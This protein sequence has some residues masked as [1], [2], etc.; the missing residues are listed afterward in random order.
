MTRDLFGSILFHE[1]QAEVDLEQVLKYALTPVP[2]S[3]SHV[4]GTIQKTPKSKLLRELEKRLES[5]TQTKINVT[6]ID[7]MFFRHFLHDPPPFG[8]VASHV[9]VTSLQ[10]ERIRIHLAFDKTISPSIKDAERCKSS[11]N[12]NTTYQITGADQK[13]PMNWFQALRQDQLKEALV[14]FFWRV[15]GKM[16]VLPQYWVRKSCLKIMV[17]R[18]SRSKLLIITWC[19]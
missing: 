14:D 19:S 10:T 3:I 9:F 5:S 13:W 12:R 1:L 11:D 17:I 16:M 15:I 18:V 7:A 8:G 6:V 4:D 2:L